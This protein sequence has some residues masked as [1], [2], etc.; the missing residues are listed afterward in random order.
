M[1]KANP[2]GELDMEKV[3]DGFGDDGSMESSCHRSQ[4]TVKGDI[5]PAPPITS[6]SEIEQRKG[7]YGS[8]EDVHGVFNAGQNP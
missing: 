2:L 7:H 8:G 3:V 4:V 6:R 5:H 1:A